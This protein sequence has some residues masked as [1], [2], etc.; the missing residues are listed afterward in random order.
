MQS[1]VAVAQSNSIAALERRTTELL[2]LSN[3][4]A[5]TSQLLSNVQ[6]EKRMLQNQLATGTASVTDL[7][8]ER[9]DLRRQVAT[10]P[11]LQQQVTELTANANQGKFTQASL[12]ETL[13]RLQL[14]KADLERKLNDPAFLR[15][16]TKRAEEQ[17]E[18]I[19]RTA[20]HP[21][22]KA[23][24]KRAHLELQPDGSVQP[25]IAGV[26]APKAESSQ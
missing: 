12:Q 9:D 17:A 19:K 23:T 4:F 5:Q 2:T 11:H 26:G 1:D 14:E 25:V 18:L 21:H 15:A 22:T 24:D 13:G 10:V 20:F 6:E 3:R 16:Q 8:A 7:Q